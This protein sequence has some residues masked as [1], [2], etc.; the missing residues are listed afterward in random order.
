MRTKEEVAK[1]SELDPELAEVRDII[2]FHNGP[3]A[4]QVK[5]VYEEQHHPEGQLGRHQTVPRNA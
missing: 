4:K 3:Y 2:A 5:I 1:L